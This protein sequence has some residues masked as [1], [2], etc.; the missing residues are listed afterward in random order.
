[1]VF[2][3]FTDRFAID[4][5]K[6]FARRDGIIAGWHEAI[7]FA[8]NALEV[9]TNKAA[10]DKVQTMCKYVLGEDDFDNKLTQAKG[11]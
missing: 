9:M 10:D 8:D 5:T 4:N 1:M 11:Q 3:N 2:Q 6:D 7:D